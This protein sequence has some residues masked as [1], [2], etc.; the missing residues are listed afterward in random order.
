MRAIVTVLNYLYCAAWAK[1]VCVPM[2][3]VLGNAQMQV[4]K[5]IASRSTG[6]WRGAGLWAR[7]GSGEEAQVKEI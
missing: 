1:P 5:K 2:A 4:V 3:R 6:F 7:I